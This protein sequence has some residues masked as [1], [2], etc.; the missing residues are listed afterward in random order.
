MTMT[1]ELHYSVCL[2]CGMILRG[3]AETLSGHHVER[4]AMG[5]LVIRA[6]H[7]GGCGVCGQDR[8]EVRWGTPPSLTSSGPPARD[9]AAARRT[10]G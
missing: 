4:G 6:R 3:S 7:K 8:V 9:S 10:F 1:G 2:R 5:D